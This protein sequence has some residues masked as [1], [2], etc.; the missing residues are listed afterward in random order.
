[1]IADDGIAWCGS[2]DPAFF[3]AE[4][5]GE[6]AASL[7]WLSGDAGACFPVWYHAH[8]PAAGQPCKAQQFP[9]LN[10]SFGRGRAVYVSLRELSR[11]R[12][13]NCLLV[14]RVPIRFPGRA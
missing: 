5:I 7:G 4:F 13:S 1:M 2:L 6:Y 9:N 12:V 14:A 10:F 11:H 8:P 3:Y